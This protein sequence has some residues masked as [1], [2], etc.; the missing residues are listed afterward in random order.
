MRWIVRTAWLAGFLV[1]ISGC[2]Q[3]C[4]ISEK[5]WNHYHSLMPANLENDASASQSP[6][7]KDVPYPK[8]STVLNPEKREKWEMSLA[9]A[10]AI[11]LEN[12]TTGI[13]SVRQPGNIPDD[14]IFVGQ[15]P[16]IQLAIDKIRVLALGPAVQGAGVEAALSKFDAKWVSQMLWQYT[17]Q[18]VQGLTSFNNGQRASFESSIIKPLATGGL[19]GITFSNTYTNLA[20]PPTA[21]PIQNPAYQAR[22]DFT[23]DQP[24]LQNFGVDIN[25]LLNRHPGTA[26]GSRLTGPSQSFLGS[27]LGNVAQGLSAG[28]GND[29]ILIARARFDQSRAEF[30]RLVNYQLFNVETAYWN[31]YA[32]YVSLYASEQGMRQAHEI[33]SIVKPKADV[34]QGT[35]YDADRAKGQYELFRGDRIQA[36]A[37]VQENERVL[38]GLLG[39]K[40]DDGKQIVPIDS[41]TLA[42]YIPDWDTA[43][44]EALNLRPELIAA[45]EELKIRQ[46][47]MLLQK[48]FLKPDLRFVSRYGISGLGSRL[49]GDGSVFDP[50]TGQFRSNNAFR[51][52]ASTNFNDWDLG[53]TLNIPLGYR[54]EHASVRRARLA[55][56]Q[57]WMAVKNEEDKSIR[58]LTKAYRDLFESYE[59]IKAR[60]SQREGFTGKL[61]EYQAKI[62]EGKI[63]ADESLL[64]A[65][66]DWVNALTQEYQAIAAYNNALAAFQFAKGT[67]QQHNSV[68]ISEGPLPVCAQVRAVEHERERSKALVL[69]E[70]AMPVNHMPL[71]P[72]EGM[73]GLPILPANGAPSVPALMEGAANINK[74]A[75]GQANMGDSVTKKMPSTSPYAKPGTNNG[76]TYQWMQSSSNTVQKQATANGPSTFPATPASDLPKTW[77]TME[78]TPPPVPGMSPSLFNPPPRVEMSVT[79]FSP[80]SPVNNITD[81]PKAG[82]PQN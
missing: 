53:F 21:F 61:K 58:Y 39:L 57:T 3:Q 8:P 16:Q 38:R 51:N 12:G 11:A 45:R 26:P 75:P 60:R 28:F 32:S 47:D 64:Q 20:Q 43:V 13:Q 2:S 72:A 68:V 42:P 55:L 52:L 62:K 63:A 71:A 79:P 7:N 22:L 66:R 76:P 1:L 80:G 81:L 35:Q 40:G 37:R 30:E 15:L 48:N 78:S 67:L 34:G 9:E 56:A 49:D 10:V 82:W 46:M 4:F 25:Q 33:W 29:G 77:S 73:L 41:P 65:Q 74:Q 27:H 24:L 54:F 5:D 18:Q 14:L 70:R 59:L 69:R 44:Q 36:L 6:L 19:A 50:S 31:L 23:F 17:D